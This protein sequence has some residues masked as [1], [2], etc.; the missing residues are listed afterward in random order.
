MTYRLKHIPTG[1][2]YR[3]SRTVKYQ[4]SR[5]ELAGWKVKSNL[6]ET[7]KEYYDFP[8][9]AAIG[10]TI[11]SHLDYDGKFI[12]TITN[13]HWWNRDSEYGYNRYEF[14]YSEWIIEFTDR[15]TKTVINYAL[16]EV[17]RKSL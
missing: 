1:L 14:D 2:Y 15:R 4:G 10:G 12:E 16:V 13:Y 11:T 17:E 9:L 7:G 6:C 8:P 5:E 3:P